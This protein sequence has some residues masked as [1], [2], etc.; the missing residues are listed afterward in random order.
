MYEQEFQITD[1]ISNNAFSFS[2]RKEP[3][4]TVPSLINGDL[5]DIKIGNKVVFEDIDEKGK[6]KSCVGLKNFIRT[7]HP[8]TKKPVIIVDNHNHVFYFWYEARNKKEIK[9][10]STLIHIDQHK[11]MR[12]PKR[13]LVKT[14]S[15]DL[16]KVFKYTNEVLN[17]GNYIPPAIKEGLVEN[18]I[19]V[20]SESELKENK[21]KNNDSL[22][23][24]I[25]LDFWAPEMDYIDHKLKIDYTKKWMN[26]A[27]LITIATSPF[28][29][30]QEIAIKV[31]HELFV[32]Q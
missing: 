22:I 18:L 1:K 2:L 15:D 8:I 21:P 24:N 11:D 25:D 10:G 5:D 23:V 28:F 26:K 14:I 9:N 4:I 3:V 20:T 13:K 16:N 7:V 30:E 19:S 29:I 32:I 27:D 17:V 6:L 12:E 31:L